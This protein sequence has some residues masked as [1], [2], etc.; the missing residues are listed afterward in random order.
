MSS[1]YSLLIAAIV[2]GPPLG[3]IRG[4]H[5]VEDGVVGAERVLNWPHNW[6]ALI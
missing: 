3:R 1:Q 4:V 2:Y 5:Q 6:R